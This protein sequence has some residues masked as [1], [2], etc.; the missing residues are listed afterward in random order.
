MTWN[1]PNVGRQSLG[2]H[3]GIY[4]ENRVVS[5]ELFLSSEYNELTENL[6]SSVSP[7]S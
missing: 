5:G 1:K 3:G 2:T 4:S 7:F 6:P